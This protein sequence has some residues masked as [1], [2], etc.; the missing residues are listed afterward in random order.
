MVEATKALKRLFRWIVPKP[1][2]LVR[3]APGERIERV[4]G[5]CGECHA[6]LLR[7]RLA[8]YEGQLAWSLVNEWVIQC[9]EVYA[10]YEQADVATA[11]WRS[12]A[13]AAAA[14]L[15]AHLDRQKGR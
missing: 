12:L 15:E 5:V 1:G 6:R 13:T 14:G 11:H 8:Y 2:A 3:L 4:P 9:G 10:L 7:G